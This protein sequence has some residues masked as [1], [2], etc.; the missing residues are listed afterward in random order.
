MTCS[1]I[2]NIPSSQTD[3][4]EEVAKL[5]R[6]RITLISQNVKNLEKACTELVYAAVDRKLLSKKKL[7]EAVKREGSS[8]KN[9]PK[10]RNE[11]ERREGC[12]MSIDF[13]R[14]V[15]CPS[16]VFDYFFLRA[17]VLLY[18]NQ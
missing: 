1:C 15:S 17:D 2:F 13:C 6:F 9:L 5:N 8:G 3:V 12:R 18:L 14:T 4:K 11:I 7:K 10:V 16:V